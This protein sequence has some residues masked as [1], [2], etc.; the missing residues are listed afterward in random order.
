[1]HR[2]VRVPRFLKLRRKFSFQSFWFFHTISFQRTS[3]HVATSTNLHLHSHTLIDSKP[4][5]SLLRDVSEMATTEFHFVDRRIVARRLRLNYLFSARTFA[6]H[7]SCFKLSLTEERSKNKTRRYVLI[8]RSLSPIYSL[9]SSF[10]Q[11][12]NKK[13]YRCRSLLNSLGMP[14]SVT[15]NFDSAL[16]TGRAIKR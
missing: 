13:N 9:I 4:W 10:I 5:L 8:S 2:F 1:M 14:A 7:P 3:K 12:Q 15:Q 11:K 16:H 6:Q